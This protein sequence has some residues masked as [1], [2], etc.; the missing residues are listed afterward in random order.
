GASSGTL[1]LSYNGQAGTAQA[2]T[3]PAAVT[4]AQVQA[5]LTSIPGGFFTT[6]NVAVLQNGLVFTIVFS[7]NLAGGR[8]AQLTSAIT[9]AGNTATSPLTNT[10]QGIGA[11]TQQLVFTT[12]P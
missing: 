1:T 7:G 10:A 3:A 11:E 5:A 2:F 4:A 8:L 12:L 9:G 6:G